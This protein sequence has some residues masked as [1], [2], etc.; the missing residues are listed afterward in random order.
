MYS[1]EEK[2]IISSMLYS[3]LNHKDVTTADHDYLL[4]IAKRKQ[5]TY[6]IKQRERIG[7]ILRGCTDFEYKVMLNLL[8]M[9]DGVTCKLTTEVM[10]RI[11]NM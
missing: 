2:R 8:L 4:Q 1:E 9:Y 7:D 6:T 5:V 3:L 11:D 10:N